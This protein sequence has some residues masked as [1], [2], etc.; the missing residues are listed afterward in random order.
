MSGPVVETFAHA[1]LGDR[2]YLVADTA[3]GVAAVVDPQRDILPY[4][5]AAQRLGCRI[6]LALETHL[7]NDFISGVRRL[8]EEHDVTVVASRLADLAFRHRAVSDGDVVELAGFRVEVVG[9]PGHTYEHVSYRVAGDPPLLFSGGALLPGGAARIDLFGPEEAKKLAEHAHR[10]IQRLLAL[11]GTTRVLPTHGAGSFC[12]S[13]VHARAESTI[14]EEREKNRFAG[15]ADPGCVLEAATRDVPPAPRYYPRVRERNRAGVLAAVVAEAIAHDRLGALQ[16][17]D[18]VTLIDARG[19]VDYAACHVKRSLVVPLQGAF[20]PWVAWLAPTDRPLAL[21]ASS[22]QDAREATLQ[23]GAVGRDDLAGFVVGVR[24]HGLPLA[25]VG[26]ADANRLQ[27]DYDA[28]IVDV[29]WDAE[30]RAGHIPYAR[31]I[32]VP[33]L[34]E[35]AAELPRDGRIAVHCASGYRSII[36]VSILERAGLTNLAHLPGGIRAWGDAGG[37]VIS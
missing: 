20:G 3:A 7:H 12:S 34:P 24:A 14:A 11:E 32:P 18:A 16:R 25:S 37:L 6:V 5:E 27:A 31:H 36:G 13:G 30:W 29:R 35:R 22:D 1:G 28:T 19:E 33:E 8:A 21:V 4:L 23:L 2:S 26:R 17:E 15:C 9:T 10:T